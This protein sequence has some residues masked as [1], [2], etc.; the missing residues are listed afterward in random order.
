MS[1]LK[2][3]LRYIGYVLWALGYSCSILANP[4]VHWQPLAPGLAYTLLNPSS[5]FPEGRIHA[6]QI[7][8]DHF[9]FKL[10]Q[11][12]G[13]G[14]SSAQFHQLMQSEKAVI[15]VNSGFF[16]KKL[17]KLEPIGLRISQGKS[18][19]LF[20]PIRWWGIFFMKQQKAYIL[21]SQE[22]PGNKGIDF[23]IQAGPILL[24][25]QSPLKKWGPS[26]EPRTVLGIDKT[27]HIILGVTENVLLSLS[28][29]SHLL[30]KPTS[31]GGLGCV[32]AI[33]LDGGSSTQ[34][35]AQVGNFHLDVPSNN[36]VAEA[37]LVIHP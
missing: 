6:F 5:Y 4:I 21:P 18:G 20:K 17:F 8:P 1:W 7:D 31:E 35:Y 26:M 22:Y 23:A 10:R 24:S 19:H 16:Y 25:Q 11:L 30:Q 3:I 29:L 12:N 33:N 9:Y 14:T 34:L 37:I 27:G 36:H 13:E 28:E 2:K 15:A 32:S